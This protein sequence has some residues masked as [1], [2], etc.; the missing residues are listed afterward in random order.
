MHFTL[1]IEHVRLLKYRLLFVFFFVGLRVPPF[2]QARPTL[3]DFKT[4]AQ[5]FFSS[6][7]LNRL[8]VALL[9]KVF[10]VSGVELFLSWGV[11]N[12]LSLSGVGFSAATVRVGRIPVDG[13]GVGER[14]QIRRGIV[15]DTSEEERVVSR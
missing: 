13:A 10:V 12:F 15:I 4:L 7:L 6:L 3:L 5:L 14:V 1:Q 9:M 8:F 2:L 11:D